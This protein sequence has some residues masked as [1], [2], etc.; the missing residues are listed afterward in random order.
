MNHVLQG[1]RFIASKTAKRSLNRAYA[2][3]RDT[4]LNI[5]QSK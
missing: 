1:I 3:E 4:P 5:F 2:S